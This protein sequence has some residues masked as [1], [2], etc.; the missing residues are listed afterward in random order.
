MDGFR[1][2]DGGQ[3]AVALIGKDDVFLGIGALE[4]GGHSR[5]AAVRRLD[6]IAVKVVIGHD[7]AADG[8]HAD[9]AALD[10]QLVDG[11]RHKAMH[12]AVRA[13]GAIMQR[14]VGKGVRFLKDDHLSAPPF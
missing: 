14:R 6:H 10:A 11:L 8:R 13:A 3:I 12:D 5:S 1:R 7:R 2:A 9:R 4:T